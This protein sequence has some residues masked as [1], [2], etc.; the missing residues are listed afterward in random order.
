MKQTL[1]TL[2]LILVV[3]FAF[4]G[5]TH[6]QRCLSYEPEVVELDGQLVVQSKYGPP[7]FGEQPK[8][9][10]KVQV[11]VLLLRERAVVTDNH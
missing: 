8:T 6:A 11:P 3:V 1:T 2:T 5:A 9:D 4:A 10:Q 7:N